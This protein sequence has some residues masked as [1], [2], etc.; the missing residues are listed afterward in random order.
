M[1]RLF[2]ILTGFGIAVIGGISVIA[3]LNLLT[4]GYDLYAFLHFVS[5]RVECLL[6]P[7]GIMMIWISIYLP[8]DW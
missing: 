6:L 1:F 8:S 4:A 7:I 3:Y 2:M 5:S